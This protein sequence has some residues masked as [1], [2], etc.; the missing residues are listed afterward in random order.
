MKGGR[1]AGQAEDVQENLKKTLVSSKQ[2]FFYWQYEKLKNDPY[3]K[4]YLDASGQMLLDRDVTLKTVRIDPQHWQRLNRLARYQKAIEEYVNQPGMEGGP[5]I[6]Q[7]LEFG[8]PETPAIHSEVPQGTPMMTSMMSMR[9]SYA[10]VA[11]IRK[12]IDETSIPVDKELLK[13]EFEKVVKENPAAT[14]VFLSETETPATWKI[15]DDQFSMEMVPGHKVYTLKPVP[16]YEERSDKSQEWKGREVYANAT[17]TSVGGGN[18][19]AQI[20]DLVI[21]AAPED[22]RAEMKKV[23][24]D[25]KKE[26]PDLKDDDW[27]KVFSGTSSGEVR[28]TKEG[29][30]REAPPQKSFSIERSVP[31]PSE[32]LK[33]KATQEKGLDLQAPS[34]SSPTPLNMIRFSYGTNDASAHGSMATVAPYMRESDDVVREVGAWILKQTSEAAMKSEGSSA[35]NSVRKKYWGIVA[36]AALAVLSLPSFLQAAEAP[37]NPMMWLKGNVFEDNMLRSFKVPKDLKERLDLW[38]SIPDGIERRMINRSL[39][40]YDGSAGVIASVLDPQRK[41]LNLANTFI[42]TLRS[43]SWGEMRSIRASGSQ[44]F[45]YGKDKKVLGPREALFFRTVSDKWKDADP[46]TG[47]ESEW[48]DWKPIMGENAWI[49]MAALQTAH[50]KYGGNILRN[51]EEV[52]LAESLIPAFKALTDD[53]GAIHHAPEGTFEKNP[54]DISNENNFSA[55]AGLRM[56]YEVT[57]DSSY[58]K[59]M[60]GIEEYI[61]KYGLDK[62]AGI[63][64]Q[65]GLYDGKEFRPNRDF[66]VDVQTWGIVSF[67]PKKLD[68]MYGEGA[69][70]RMWKTTKARSGY[71][72]D[73]KLFGVGYTDSHDVFSGEWTAGAIAACL[74]LSLHYKDSHPSWAEEALADAVSMT[75]GLESLSRI[76]GDKKGYLYVNKSV[77][78]P[79][80]WNGR[81]VESTASTAW[82][83]YVQNFK[84]PFR[85]GGMT[86]WQ[87]LA[88][89]RETVEEIKASR[90][91]TIAG[92][93]AQEAPKPAMTGVAADEEKVNELISTSAFQNAGSGGSSA[94]YREIKEVIKE[95]AVPALCKNLLNHGANIESRK[96]SGELLIEVSTKETAPWI[97]W[98]FQKFRDTAVTENERW[99]AIYQKDRAVNALRERFGDVKPVR[100]PFISEKAM[101]VSAIESEKAMDK[102][103]GID[104]SAASLDMQIRR[105]G[106]GMVLPVGQ[107]DLDNI[108]IDGLVPVIFKIE[109]AST[110]PLFSE[111][112]AKMGTGSA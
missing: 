49:I 43:D 84:D 39:N 76:D 19:L 31:L 16:F 32:G 63:L 40:F 47:E 109:P 11:D 90:V 61:K 89:F 91:T 21:P 44:Y 95:R 60:D 22:Q 78:I 27:V 14:H 57:G 3:N 29:Q 68:E 71:S 65:G 93:Q 42:R 58:K 20:R 54:N 110:L 94:P 37:A 13:S 72:E 25:F 48:K 4:N 38:K 24:D 70:Y 81:P 79:F 80:G 112:E 50:A 62:E 102:T 75:K 30:F 74:E 52:Q 35:L 46:L 88:K 26:N 6:P 69:S 107:Q 5:R 99:V 83:W 100:P 41:D 96:W 36:A 23:L 17:Y 59:M 97:I 67:S 56:L 10:T 9:Q 15:A 104:F 53:I 106:K 64:Y 101:T 85:L 33:T 28:V 8:S 55:Y 105:D 45:R 98:T 92:P 86:R 66:A 77:H 34:S 51:S 18:T 73:G 103:G 87:E 7:V 108:K 111:L 12:Q 2:T 1:Q 82:A